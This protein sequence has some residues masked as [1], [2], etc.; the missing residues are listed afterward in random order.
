[1]LPPMIDSVKLEMLARFEE[2]F[3]AKE[4]AMMARCQA[5]MRKEI[6]GF[7]VAARQQTFAEMKS[8]VASRQIELDA[9]LGQKRQNQESRQME[10]PYHRDGKLEVRFCVLCNQFGHVRASCPRFP[11]DAGQN[12]SFVVPKC[13]GVHHVKMEDPKLE[14]GA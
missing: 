13:G 8:V 4:E 7:V 10:D 2:R 11:G 1:M 14:D 12:L 5:M 3:A 6:S 9:R